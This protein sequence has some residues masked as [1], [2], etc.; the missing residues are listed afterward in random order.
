MQA[1]TETIMSPESDSPD[2]LV[3]RAQALVPE[4]RAR[5]AA[6]EKAGHA[7]PEAIESFQDAGL[8]RVVQPKK[9]GGYEYGID[10]VSY[11][12]LTLPTTPYV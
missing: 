4:L 9:F 10:T 8:Y 2:A 7:L 5:Q 11:T 1:N 3:A 12:H 6:T